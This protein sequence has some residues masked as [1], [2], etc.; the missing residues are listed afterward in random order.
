MS[1]PFCECQ[2]VSLYSYGLEV[3]AV[4]LIATVS[5]SKICQHY[6]DCLDE[7]VDGED[8]AGFD[9]DDGVVAAVVVGDAVIADGVDY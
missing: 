3:V 5:V 2:K 8:S 7:V 1:L 6:I 4:A 9:Y